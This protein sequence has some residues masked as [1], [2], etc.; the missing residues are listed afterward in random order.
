MYGVDVGNDTTV[1]DLP[2]S[3]DGCKL[4]EVGVVRLLEISLMLVM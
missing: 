2:Y 1:T 3:G 4:C